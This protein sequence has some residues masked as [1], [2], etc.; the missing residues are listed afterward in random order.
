MICDSEEVSISESESS[1]EGTDIFSDSNDNET[2]EL[3]DPRV[4]VQ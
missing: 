2:A 4:G 3:L 1:S